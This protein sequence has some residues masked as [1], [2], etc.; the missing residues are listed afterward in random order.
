MVCPADLQFIS[1]LPG[2]DPTYT[3]VYFNSWTSYEENGWLA[4]ME[5]NSQYYELT[6]GY[7]VM[8]AGPQD[9]AW[10]LY[11]TTEDAAL[12]RM[13]QFDLYAEEEF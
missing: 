7:S 3:C 9:D 11:P 12:E 1:E 2:Y 5:K 13:I 10:D 6:G 8:A 4:I